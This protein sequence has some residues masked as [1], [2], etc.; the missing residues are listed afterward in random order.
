MDQAILPGKYKMKF[1][2]DSV[3]TCD[4]NYNIAEE[5]EGNFNNIIEITVDD[6]KL[7]KKEAKRENRVIKYE[8]F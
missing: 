3:F 7:I 1:I 6:S 4:G 8:V 2:V 5:K